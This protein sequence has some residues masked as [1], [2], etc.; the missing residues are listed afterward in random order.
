[1]PEDILKKIGRCYVCFRKDHLSREFESNGKW[2]I[3][4]GRRHVSICESN[5]LKTGTGEQCAKPEQIIYK[6]GS[7]VRESEIV[8]HKLFEG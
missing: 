3:C 4:G 8:H 5:L 2:F 1:M 7:K 6:S